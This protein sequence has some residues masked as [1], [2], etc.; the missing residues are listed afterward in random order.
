MRQHFGSFAH[1][2]PVRHDH[3]S[4]YRARAV[5]DEIAF[6]GAE[7]L[8]AFVRAPEGTAAPSALFTPQGE[9]PLGAAFDIVDDQRQ[10]LLA[11]KHCE[12][13]WDSELI[14]IVSCW[15]CAND[16]VRKRTPVHRQAYTDA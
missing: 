6:L 12:S 2:L 3:G 7:S 14:G 9:P 4:Q 5:Q 1:G 8:P 11:F 13:A 15:N 16:G 10:A